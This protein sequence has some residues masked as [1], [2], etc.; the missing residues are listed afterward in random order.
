MHSQGIPGRTG[1]FDLPFFTLGLNV[2]VFPSKV[3]ALIGAAPRG[4][5][6][7][8]ENISSSAF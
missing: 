3:Y 4:S 6:T 2:I 5:S 1:G 7:I 8:V